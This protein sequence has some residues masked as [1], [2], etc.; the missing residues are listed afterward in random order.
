M[1]EAPIGFSPCVLD[2]VAPKL[3]VVTQLPHQKQ[4]TRPWLSGEGC[5]GSGTF[6][7]TAAHPSGPS[8]APSAPASSVSRWPHRGRRVPT[9]PRH[10]EH[11]DQAPL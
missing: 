7:P 4:Q 1:S 9:Q 11:R 3:R 6:L 8:A 10:M 5:V 2:I